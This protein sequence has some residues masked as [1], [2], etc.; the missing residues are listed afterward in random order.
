MLLMQYDIMEIFLLG[1][2]G[3]FP[4]ALGR[5]TSWLSYWLGRSTR[6]DNLLGSYSHLLDCT[7]I[8]VESKPDY[9]ISVAILGS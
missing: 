1:S 9:V 8:R 2:E 6:D 5:N 3:Q 4:G 7:R